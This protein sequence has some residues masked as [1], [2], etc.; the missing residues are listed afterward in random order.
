MKKTALIEKV[1]LVDTWNRN[2]G[3]VP[4]N[5][6]R[7]EKL[8]H[9][10]SY[11][12]IFDTTNRRFLVQERTDTKDYLPGAYDLS[13]GGVV[14]VDEPRQLNAERELKE[15]MGL[16]LVSDRRGYITSWTDCGYHSYTDEL[17]KVWAST[18]M[19]RLPY[20]KIE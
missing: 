16:D 8:W 14:G 1:M 18:Y 2:L 17:T 19:Y 13:T 5:I 6:M 4:R 20:K 15:E 11:V 3:G 10:A 12:F 9:R 7:A